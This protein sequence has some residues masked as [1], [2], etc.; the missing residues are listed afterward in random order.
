MI[1]ASWAFVAGL[2]VVSLF[3]LAHREPWDSLVGL[4]NATPWVY[5]PAWATAAVGLFWRRRGLAVVS[6]V[7]VALQLWW[8]VP[9]F[10]PVSHLVKARPGDVSVQLF[11][12]NCSQANTNLT[13]VAGEIRRDRPEVVAMEELTPAGFRSLSATGVMAHYRHRL[14]MP[15]TGSYGMALWSTFPL[16]KATVWY[17]LGHPELRAWLE[18]PGGRRLRL[19]VVHVVAPYG[20]GGPVPWQAQLGV[21]RDQLATEPHPLVVVGDFNATWFDWHFQSVLGTGLRDAAVLAG[22]GWRMT[23]PRDQGLVVPY[24]AID[25]VLLSKG[26]GLESYQVSHG[27]AGSD[28]HP[29]IVTLLMGQSVTHGR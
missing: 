3:H 8:V 11:D 25:H 16:S 22:Q 1:G 21:V 2:V 15:M 17:S 19:D 29:V 7:L 4:I 28:H 14:V 23:W 13:E 10:N 20:Y 5:M 6:V 12:W 27:G 26:V 24:L 9:D 18:L